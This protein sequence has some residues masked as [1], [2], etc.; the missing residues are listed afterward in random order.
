MFWE[1]ASSDTASSY[2]TCRL[3]EE[4]AID[5]HASQKP[6]DEQVS[7]KDKAL[8][9]QIPTPSESPGG[10]IRQDLQTSDRRPKSTK[11]EISQNQDF[12]ISTPLDFQEQH[13]KSKQGKIG[14]V[15]GSAERKQHLPRW[16]AGEDANLSKGYQIYGFQWTAITKDPTLNLGHRTGPQV[17]DRFRLK[18]PVQYNASVP[19]PLPPDAPEKSR[20]QSSDHGSNIIRPTSK[21]QGNHRQ[22]LTWILR[23]SSEPPQFKGSG[24]LLAHEPDEKDKFEPPSRRN[25]F[26]A[27]YLQDDHNKPVQ[28]QGQKLSGADQRTVTSQST[29][30]ASLTTGDRSR[31]TSMEMEIDE[32]RHMNIESKN[33]SKP[34]LV[35]DLLNEDESE[36]HS[37]LPPFKF[38]FDNDWSN[39]TISDSV[40]LPPLLWEDMASRPLFDLE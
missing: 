8:I 28:L 10:A 36:Q 3:N 9:T 19:L 11:T 23:D 6:D 38:P 14:S 15:A 32:T 17:R 39:E 1:A 18:F 27:K 29:P 37:R 40:T 20:R 21:I 22:E 13:S 7:N 35:N 25:S 24:V 2:R 34:W 26:P 16:T 33:G 12:N 5:R 31:Q 30:P 4:R